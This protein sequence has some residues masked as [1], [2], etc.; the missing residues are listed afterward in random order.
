MV[1]VAPS[2]VSKASNGSM[3]VS[4]GT[5]ARIAS[6][7]NRLGYRP[8]AIAPSLKVR[9]THTLGV[10]TNDRSGEFTTAMLHGVAEVATEHNFGVSL[11]NSYGDPSKERRH[12]ELL[13]DKQVDGLILTGNKVEQRGA[14]AAAT[15]DV[16]L[17]YLYSY[18]FCH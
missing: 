15:G 16:P 6:A 5:R 7:A 11:C 18:T 12:I 3:E 14:P 1:G 17:V 10:I 8:N 2:T 9:R 4:E 13:F